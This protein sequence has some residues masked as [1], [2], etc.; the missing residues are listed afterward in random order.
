VDRHWCLIHATHVTPAERDGIAASGAV[1]GLCPITEANLGD[2]V[3]PAKAFTGAFGV[4]TDSNVLIDAAAELRQLEYAQRLAQ[5][6]RN[7]L[8]AAAPATGTSLW[9]SAAAGGAR[10]LGMEG[11]ITLGAPANF[12]TLDAAGLGP[13]AAQ[14]PETA[15]NAAIFA[16]RTPMVDGVWVAGKQVVHA[17][18]HTHAGRV[19]AAFHAMLARRL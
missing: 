19:R 1:A 5:R 4:G 17:G 7:V 2:G 18:R 14:G 8:T 16:A 15:L 6:Q 11:G 13:V 3:F 10:A 12:V 9:Q